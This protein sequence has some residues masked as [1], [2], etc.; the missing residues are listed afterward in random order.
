[1]EDNKE[2]GIALEQAETALESLSSHW[3]NLGHREY[4]NK[5]VEERK[6]AIQVIMNLCSIIRGKI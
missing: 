3:S 5:L 4:W 1:M 2:V 6:T